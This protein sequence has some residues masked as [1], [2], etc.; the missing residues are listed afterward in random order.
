MDAIRISLPCEIIEL[1]LRYMTNKSKRMLRTA[2]KHWFQYVKID[3]FS[4]YFATPKKIPEI[5]EHFATLY[6][7]IPI[8]ISL[9][10]IVTNKL[11]EFSHWSLLDGLTHLTSF[12]TLSPLFIP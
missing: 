3:E 6:E 5:V 2:N 9:L 4:I 12:Q 10:K 8:G 7:D 11:G 1:I